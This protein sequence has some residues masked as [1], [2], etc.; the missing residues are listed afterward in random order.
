M[1]TRFLAMIVVG[2]AAGCGDNAVRYVVPAAA[3]AAQP[4][5]LRVST[6]EVRDAV[7]PDYAE[8]PEILVQQADGGLAPVKKAIW[9]D[10]SAR[11]VTA[12]LVDS[13]AVRSRAS[14]AAEPWPLSSPPDARLHVR[15]SRMV[16]ASDGRFALEG[17]FAIEAMEGRESIRPFSVTVPLPDSSPGGIAAAKGQALG[18]LADLIVAALRV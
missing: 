10:G 17:Q 5:A 8:A 12:T 1:K 3:G 7:L 2:L 13:L 16:A 14:V 15:I 18:Q 11:A 9:G 6:L 4:A